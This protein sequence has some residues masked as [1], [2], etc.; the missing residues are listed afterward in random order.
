ML[1]LAAPLLAGALAS[2][3]APAR[4]PARAP[5]LARFTADT[6]VVEASSELQWV[7]PLHVV[8]RY[9]VGIYLDTMTCIVQDLDPGETHD[10]RYMALDASTLVRDRGVSAGDSVTLQYLV[11]ATSEHA[12]LLFRL[13]LHRMDN[14][15][16]VLL[17]AVEALPGPVSR[18]HPSQFLTVAGKRVEYVFFPSTKDSA[19]NPAPGVLLVHSNGSHARKMMREAGRLSQRG[20][21]VM[22]VSMPGFGQSDGPPDFAGPATS[23]ALDA[24]LD[25]LESTPGVDSKRIAAWGVSRG[26]GAVALLAE[27]RSDVRAALVESGIYDLW[28]VY[29][30]TTNPEYQAV[31]VQQ[32]GSDS[33]GWRERSAALAPGK[34]ASI[35]I[36]HGERDPGVPVDQ[37]RGFAEVL[38]A[39]GADVELRT[40]PFAEHRIAAGEVLRFALEFFQR[41]LGG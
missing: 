1:A 9:P 7:V 19:K 41:R 23:R 13:S 10:G 4:A 2:Q 5:E 15:R 8:N 33:S 25:Q 21:A 16:S 22:L 18:D 17:A 36:L 29:R 3:A 12:R 32:A 39:R 34:P 37:A 14:S 28:A 40:F 38:K 20:F 31:I 6:A 27:R 11:P 35:L 30:A 26:A 24:A